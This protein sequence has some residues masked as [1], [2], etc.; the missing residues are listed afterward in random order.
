MHTCTKSN[1][2]FS[3]D[4]YQITH[5]LFSTK[6]E[7]I[8]LKFIWTHK[9]AGIAKPN[10]KKKNKA[11]GIIISDFRQYYKATVIKIAWYWHKNRH[12]DQWNRM[13][14]LEIN[15]HTYGQ[16]VFDKGVKNIQWEKKNTVSSASHVENVGQTHVNQ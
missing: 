3:C 5:Y 16:L 11:G 13:G 14:N 12:M 4:P 7:K 9:R 15:A 10:L 2:Q 6:L 1:L 8:I